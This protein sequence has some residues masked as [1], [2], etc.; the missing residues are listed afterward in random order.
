MEVKSFAATMGIGMVAGA[1]VAM[2]LPKKSPVRKA[3]DQAAKSIQQE[4][5]KMSRMMMK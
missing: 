1:T 5:R 3:A 2:M 4:V